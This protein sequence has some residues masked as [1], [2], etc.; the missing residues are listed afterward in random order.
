MAIGPGK[1]DAELT[2]AARQCGATGAL[3][4]VLDG[5]RGPGWACQATLEQLARLP[6]VLESIAKQMRADRGSVPRDA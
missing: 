2:K 3:L 4:I 5:T 1:Y 6:E